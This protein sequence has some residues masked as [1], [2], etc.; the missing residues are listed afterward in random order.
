MSLFENCPS[1][2]L[3]PTIC[4]GDGGLGLSG[5]GS[6]DHRFCAAMG[7]TCVCDPLLLVERMLEVRNFSCELGRSLSETPVFPHYIPMIYHGCNRDQPTEVPWVA[8]PLEQMFSRSKNGV[9][10]LI[11]ESPDALR[12]YLSVESKTKVIVT[13]VGPDQVIEDFWGAHRKS[14]LLNRLAGLDVQAL[15]IPNYSFPSD[16]PRIHHRYNRSRILRMAERASTAGLK[17]ILHLNAFLEEDWRDWENLLKAHPEIQTVC[18]EFQ[19]GYASP[20]LGD[21]AFKR[22]TLLQE[23]VGR[24]IHPILVGGARY[25]TRLAA[26]F[27]SS[28]STV[29]DSQ[30]FMKTVNRKEC[31]LAGNGKLKWRP[32]SSRYGQDRHT[33]LQANLF[34]YGEFL[35]RSM[36]LRQGILQDEP[37]FLKPVNK[38]KA[39]QSTVADWEL[40][41]LASQGGGN[42]LPLS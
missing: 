1:C 33:P 41:A 34:R 26:A 7:W 4:H 19:T 8:V 24:A 3:N 38:S 32:E 30:P 5:C 22:L 35:A 2:K 12:K 40:F 9:I 27:G 6:F 20:I 10:R 36:G 29:I 16:C 23:N 39:R 21:A 15:T 18:L 28:G 11:S 42:D 25:S 13:G 31:H 17:P 14:N 37:E